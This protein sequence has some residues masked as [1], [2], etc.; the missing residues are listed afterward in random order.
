M[1]KLFITITIDTENPQN[2]LVKGIYRTDT[3]LGPKTGNYGARYLLKL[4]ENYGIQASWFLNVYEEFLWGDRTLGRLCELLRIYKQDI[5]LHTHPVWLMDRENRKKQFMNQYTLDE[6][7]YIL[8]KGREE[9]FRLS[10]I[11]PSAHRGGAYGA[12]SN[13]LRALAGTSIKVDCSLYKQ[14]PNCRIRSK[15]SN[16]IH[17]LEGILEIPV[18]VYQMNYG[19]GFNRKNEVIMKSDL[20]YSSYRDLV[21]CCE[22]MLKNNMPY[23]NIFMHSFSL[24]KLFD[25]DITSSEVD[26]TPEQNSIRKLVKFLEYVCRR[27][28]MKIVT[29]RELERKIVSGEI[30]LNSNDYIPIK[31]KAGR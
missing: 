21:F 26:F 31:R 25:L 8:E 6:Q 10:G 23:L 19:I 22:K 9:I 15:Y 16:C 24:Y 28:E 4:F 18:S 2:A 17:N 7:I 14:S 12:N 30:K 5:Q 11:W 3:L 13:T 29:V 1:N 27:P 20:N